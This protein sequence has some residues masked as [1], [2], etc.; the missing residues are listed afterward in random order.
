MRNSDK[1]TN[2]DQRRMS[3]L[4]RTKMCSN[5]I[6]WQIKS[7]SVIISFNSILYNEVLAEVD[8][9]KLSNIP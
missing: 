8:F 3:L 9:T 5:K 1:V 4:R 7:I 2:Q 6:I